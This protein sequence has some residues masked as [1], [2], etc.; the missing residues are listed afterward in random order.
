[1]MS[2]LEKLLHRTKAPAEP[3]LEAPAIDQAPAGPAPATGAE[4]DVQ[5]FM[6][7]EPTLTQPVGGPPSWAPECGTPAFSKGHPHH[8]G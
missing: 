1:M 8:T 3:V 7:A 4:D 2:A 5:G 6:D